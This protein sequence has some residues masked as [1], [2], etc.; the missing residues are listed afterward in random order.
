M[1][2]DFSLQN[3][4]QRIPEWKDYV[5]AGSH[6][7]LQQIYNCRTAVLGYH[8]Y[9]CSNI[10]CN[11]VHYQYHS[12]RNRHCPECDQH[13][14]DD[15]AEARQ[16]ELIPV[17]YFHVVFTLPKELKNIVELNRILLY[18]LLFEAAKHCIFTL[19]A[20]KKYLGAMPYMTSVLH[21]WGQQL[22]FH[23]HVHSIVSAGGIDKNF[24][25]VN[26]KK[27]TGNFLFPYKVMEP[28]YKGFFME[29]LQRLITAHKIHLPDNISWYKLKNFLYKKRWIINANE[30]FGNPS[31]VIE[32]LSRYTHKVAIS[33]HRILNIDN[34]NRITFKYK[35][36]TEQGKYKKTTLEGKEFLRRYVKHILPKGFVKI[37]HYGIAGNYKRR[38]RINKLLEKMK[39]PKH[40]DPVVIPLYIRML[41]KYGV[42]ITLCPKC[43]KGKLE[44]ISIV[45][46]DVRG[47]PVK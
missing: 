1:K 5:P 36:Y 35:D 16:N 43:R 44:L 25:W 26:L 2:P 18:N 47:S 31:Q 10:D 40:P 11:N 38:E 32:Y 12:C 21:S 29:H 6:K 42:D 15:W 14:Q 4:L 28:L 13:K 8:Y 39:L 27:T 34:D 23:P 24:K 46:P 30:P 45:Y 20:D 33:N 41:E 9:K 37:R 17:K 19:S 22:W 3:L 7:V